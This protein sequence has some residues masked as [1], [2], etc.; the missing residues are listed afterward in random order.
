MKIKEITYSH[1]ESRNYNN[2]QVS[3]TVSL[4]EGDDENEVYKRAKAWVES[5]FK[6]IETPELQR[7]RNIT[8]DSYYYPSSVV[9]A[10]NYQIDEMTK[11]LPF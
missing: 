5:K 10:A 1:L 4:G 9:E 3:V 6:D 7:L 2:T 11:D 8:R